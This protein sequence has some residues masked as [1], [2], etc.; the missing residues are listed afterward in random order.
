MLKSLGQDTR[1]ATENLQTLV[2]VRG[3]ETISEAEVAMIQR[4]HHR[5]S[6][7]T[8]LFEQIKAGVEQALQAGQE[9]QDGDGR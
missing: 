7:I 4:L 3:D 5:H 6:Q 2:E 1:N 8:R 9:Q